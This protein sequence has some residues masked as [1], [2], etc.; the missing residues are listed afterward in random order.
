[1]LAITGASAALHMSKIPFEGPIAGG[2]IGYVDNQ[3]VLNP[4]VSQLEQSTLDMVLV[5]SK[6]A[7]VMVEGSADILPHEV[8][9]EALEWGRD[10]LQPL[11]EMQEELRGQSGKDKIE[12]VPPQVDP[13]FEQAVIE[14]ATPELDEALSIKEKM[15]ARMPARQPK[16]R[17][18]PRSPRMSGSWNPPL[19]CI[20]VISYPSWKKRW[21]ASASR[22]PA[23]ALMAAT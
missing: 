20:L 10:A 4:T 7:V 12:F 3:F 13:E 22:T 11:I 6:D 18:W 2:R 15:A 16:R 9:A 8:M 1:M 17:S 21:C 19:W 14:V 5:A 23:C